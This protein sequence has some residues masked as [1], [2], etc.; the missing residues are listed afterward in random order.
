M[1]EF[2][3]ALEQAERDRARE[4]QQEEAV[5]AP[6][7]ARVASHENGAPPA[8][9][10]TAE[11]VVAKQAVAKPTVEEPA[12]PK[13]KAP[14][15]V[16][17]PAAKAAPKPAAA[18][19][20]A[21]K[22]AAAEPVVPK[23]TVAEPVASKPTVT[24]PVA[25]KPAAT[26]P[27]APKPP[28]AEP[29]I[30]KRAMAEPNAPKR[31]VS[32][33]IVA[34][35][36]SPKPAPTP[37]VVSMPTPSPSSVFRPSLRMPERPRLLGRLNGRQP[38]LISLSDPSSIEADAYRTLRAN[39]ELMSDGTALRRVAITSAAGGDGKSTTAANLAIVAAQGGRRVCLVDAD[40]RRPT[41][42]EVFGLSNVDGLD[43]AL[44]RGTS[45]E[46]VA[47]PVDIPNLS[48]V[49]AGRGPA[50]TFHDLLTPQRLDKMLRE[51]EAAF[52]FIV[53]DSPP[54]IVSDSLSIAAVSDGVV[55]VVRAGSIPVSVLQ[56]AIGQITHV[57]GRVI[58]VLLNQA[59]LRAS[60]GDAYRHYR[61]YHGTRKA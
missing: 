7:A 48:V 57:K 59:D 24:E 11:P 20:A 13:P 35:E 12:A 26:A 27:A 32:E 56:R 19:P 5:K 42:H 41:L 15:P 3:R 29:A 8:E 61:A 40:F 46:T 60:D 9:R 33:P 49:V 1:S 50:E 25:S 55:L 53:F 36:A 43:V 31:A 28:A 22:P 21:P 17:G 58:G 44:S 39:I 14:E 4:S 37:P 54:V 52:D 51:S 18:E 2:F 23:P 10:P 34:K 38:L 30:P 47:R 16:P 45:L 6:P